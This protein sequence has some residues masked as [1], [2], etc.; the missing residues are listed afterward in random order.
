MC[1]N[2]THILCIFKL[3]E[4]TIIYFTQLIYDCIYRHVRHPDVSKSKLTFLNIV[5][6][7][8]V[9][10][11]PHFF[12]TRVLT[13]GPREG[14]HNMTEEKSEWQPNNEKWGLNTCTYVIYVH[15]SVCDSGMLSLGVEIWHHWA[16]RKPRSSARLILCS[17]RFCVYK[18]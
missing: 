3:H 5:W 7:L 18:V 17:A 2:N 6:H 12:H 9:L 1:Y 16:Q 8:P 13:H 11:I 10:G 15:K 4:S 14:L